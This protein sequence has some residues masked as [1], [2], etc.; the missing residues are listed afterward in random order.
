MSM[1]NSINPDESNDATLSSLG[2]S[3]QLICFN[4]DKHS[5][6][7]DLV[8][9]VK[10]IGDGESAEIEISNPEYSKRSTII[11]TGLDLLRMSDFRQGNIIS[12]VTVFEWDEIPPELIAE[13]MYMDV[14]TLKTSKY[15]D[16]NYNRIRENKYKGLAI[17]PSYGCSIQALCKEVFVDEH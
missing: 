9:S 14:A 10:I 5:F 16:I 13:L 15:Y 12:Y 7:D 3:R 1:K 2:G 8:T 11:A 4:E 6:H 17:V